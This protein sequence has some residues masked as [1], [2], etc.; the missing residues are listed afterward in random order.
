[1]RFERGD[2]SIFYKCNIEPSIGSLFDN[3]GSCKS[4]VGFGML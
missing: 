4:C 2:Y 3:I 1:M